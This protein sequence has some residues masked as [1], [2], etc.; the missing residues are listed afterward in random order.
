MKNCDLIIEFC[1]NLRESGSLER[2]RL[3][4]QRFAKAYPLSPDIWERY[5]DIETTNIETDNDIIEIENLH[6]KALKD[7]YCK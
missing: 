6:K 4:Y 7:Y 2:I 1:C 3:A 5:I